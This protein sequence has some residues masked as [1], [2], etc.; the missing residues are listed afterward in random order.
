[1]K[2]IK[3]ITKEITIEELIEI[4]KTFQKQEII[5]EID[6]DVNNWDRNKSITI[7]DWWNNYEKQKLNK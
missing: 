1:M 7:E 3:E 5:K 2:N 6:F 4:V